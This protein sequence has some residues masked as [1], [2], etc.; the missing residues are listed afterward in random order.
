MKN[1]MEYKGYYAK[2]EYATEDRCFIGKVLGVADTL[3]FDG[4]TVEELESMFRVCVD[5]YLDL[6]LEI[7]KEPDRA[8]KGSFNV[9][10]T[11]EQHRRAALAAERQG[12]SLNQY[13]SRALE[14]YEN[15]SVVSKETT[16][17]VPMPV[18]QWAAQV[19]SLGANQYNHV[20]PKKA[21]PLCG[22]EVK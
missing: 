12:I 22:W 3:V 2:I 20:L 5:D 19:E 8:F 16:Y 4:E 9:R 17:V 15:P 13:V 10:V 11:P 14:A 21:I 18:K 1:V 6:C 7:G